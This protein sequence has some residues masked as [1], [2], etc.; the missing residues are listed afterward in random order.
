MRSEAE[1]RVLSDA[2]TRRILETAARYPRKQS[3]I[4]PAFHLAQAE[5]GWLAPDVVREICRVLDLPEKL[6][7]EVLTFYVLLEKK[8]RGKYLISVCTNVSCALCGAGE[9]I[10]ALE[11]LVGVRLGE[12]TPDGLFT[13]REVECL[14]SCGTAPV[15]LVN[16]DYVESLTPG[17]LAE[18]IEGIRRREASGGS[19][20]G[21]PGGSAG[22]SGARA[23][24]AGRG[25]RS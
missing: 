10:Q 24:D 13:L 6:G 20:G 8:P 18:T 17:K 1:A 15:V 3:A 25:G 2:L 21:A 16:D 23:E 12:T 7:F 11:K 22:V 9:L 5:L 4:L 19:A 14:A